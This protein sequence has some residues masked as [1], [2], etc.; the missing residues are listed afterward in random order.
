MKVPDLA[1]GIMIGVSKWVPTIRLTAP[2]SGTLGVGT[3]LT[4]LIVPA[5]VLQ[6]A[7]APT[8]AANGIFGV[9]SPLLITGLSVG[10]NTVF[11]QGIC[12][13]TH[14]NVGVGGGVVRFNPPPATPFLVEG[15]ASVGMV[16]EGPTRLANGLGQALGIVFS[17]LTLPCVVVGSPSPVASA[18]VGFGQIL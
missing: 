14:P 7:M 16:G 1:L 10:L 11:L 12:Q 5:P 4:P 9:M 17:A 6:L 18:G 15:L 8:F 13:T 3:G 2:S